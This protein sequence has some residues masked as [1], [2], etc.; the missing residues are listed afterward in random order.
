[1]VNHTKIFKISILSI[2][3]SRDSTLTSSNSIISQIEQELN[4]SNFADLSINSYLI[5]MEGNKKPVP[6]F[7]DDL[8][9]EWSYKVFFP[10]Y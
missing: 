3:I 4:I 6:D 8:I 10:V 2:I 7:I 9:T 5:I 1:M